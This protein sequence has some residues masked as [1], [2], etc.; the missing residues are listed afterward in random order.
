MK[1]Q[2]TAPIRINEK[3]Y[4]WIPNKYM[5]R[6][7]TVLFAREMQIEI[8]MRH[9]YISTRIDQNKQSQWGSR[10]TGTLICYW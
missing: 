5:R 6:H 1:Q 7:F 3:E 8:K 9:H 2:T 4:I 10:A